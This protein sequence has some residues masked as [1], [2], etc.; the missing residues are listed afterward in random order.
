MRYEREIIEA[1]SSNKALVVQGETGCGKSTQIPHILLKAMME[2]ELTGGVTT[3][4]ILCTEPRRISATSLARR[5][6]HEM[7]DG[8]GTNDVVA[9][10][11]RQNESFCGYQIRGEKKS[12]RNTVLT[13]MTTGF[14]YGTAE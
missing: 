2:G 12:S 8:K 7:G 3:G 6:C 5:V 4:E 14:Y 13:Y 1:V 9:G 10:S 11:N